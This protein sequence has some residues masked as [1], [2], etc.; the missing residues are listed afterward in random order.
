VLDEIKMS[1]S[2]IDNTFS[3]MEKFVG[4]SPSENDT[5]LYERGKKIMPECVVPANKIEAPVRQYDL[6]ILRTRLKFMRAEGRLQVTNQRVL[7]RATGRALTGRTTLQHSFSLSD[8]AGVEA[9]KDNR[10]SILSFLGGAL[11]S[12][13][14]AAIFGV[15]CLVAGSSSMVLALIIGIG[16]L[17]PFFVMKKHYFI[18]LICCAASF[19]SL[20]M[21]GLFYNIQGIGGLISS[22]VS[23]AVGDI[24]GSYGGYG[25]YGFGG[26]FSPAGPILS[27]LSIVSLIIGILALILFSIKP[28]FV[29]AIKTKGANGAVEIR[30]KNLRNEYTG[31]SEVLPGKDADRAIKEVNAMIQDINTR[32]IEAIEDWKEGAVSNPSH[33]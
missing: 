4:E 7:F 33:I 2:I 23:G 10:F 16:G 15:I 31:F 9:R 12:L 20:A 25:D 18:K 30:R 26:G 13:V 19:G 17:V 22:A 32:G 14:V 27:L 8:I 29:F 11:I 6:A 3:V 28:N 21:S 1:D 24:L 5:D